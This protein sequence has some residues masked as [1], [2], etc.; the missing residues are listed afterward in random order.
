MLSPAFDQQA[1]LAVN[2]AAARKVL[3]FTQANFAKLAKTSRAT[4]VQI[5]GGEGNPSLETLAGIAQACMIPLWFLFANASAIKALGP[6]RNEITIAL[7]K[8]LRFLYASSVAT[9]LN[10]RSTRWRTMRAVGDTLQSLYYSPAVRAS[11]AIG[12]AQCGV[13][14]F[15]LADYMVEI[16]ASGARLEGHG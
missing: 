9:Q 16:E 11:A 5:E 7:R 15:G 10:A 14:G 1:L 4:L 13:H 3:G 12:M 2:T 6:R 8:D